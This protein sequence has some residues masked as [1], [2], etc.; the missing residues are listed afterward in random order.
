MALPSSLALVAK[1]TGDTVTRLWAIGKLVSMPPATQAP[2]GAT[3]RFLDGRVGVEHIGAGQLIAAGIEMAAEVRQH[4]AVQVLVFEVQNAPRS[5]VFLGGQVQPEGIRI[6]RVEAGA[7]QGELVERRDGVGRPFLI[8]GDREGV[9]PYAD[10]AGLGAQKA[11]AGNQNG[12]KAEHIADESTT[13]QEIG[14]LKTAVRAVRR[15]VLGETVA[16]KR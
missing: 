3:S 9:L 10:A 2:R 14:D 8:S 16:N 12:G 13:F 1:W 6:D 4:Q 7:V 15:I 5:I 11:R